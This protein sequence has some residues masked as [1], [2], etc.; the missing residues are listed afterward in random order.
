MTTPS[1][2][3]HWE[4]RARLGRARRT[5]LVSYFFILF[6][7]AL[8]ATIVLTLMMLYLMGKAGSG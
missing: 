1:I 2:H 4:S 8:A 6:A 7:T 5:R 3:L